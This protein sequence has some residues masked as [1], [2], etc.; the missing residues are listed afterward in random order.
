MGIRLISALL[1][2][3]PLLGSSPTRVVLTAFLQL[4]PAPKEYGDSPRPS[5]ISRLH[6]TESAAEKHLIKKLQPEY[7]QEAKATG[8]EGEVVFRILIG[9]DG[10]VK[11]IH[12]RRGKPLLIEGAAKAVSQWQYE[13]YILNGKAAEIETFA[14]V[15]FP[16]PEQTH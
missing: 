12:L 14:T 3:S 11:E 4:Q 15:R 8:V 2:A 1:F 5:P 7:P 16:R 10:R 6:M 9:T 13:P